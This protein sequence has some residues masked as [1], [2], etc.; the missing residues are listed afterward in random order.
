MLRVEKGAE[1]LYSIHMEHTH[2]NIWKHFDQNPLTHSA[3]HY[4]MTIKNLITENGYARLTDI[5]RSLNITPGSCSLSLKVLKKKGWI[6]EDT[7]KFLK[8][9]TTGEKL[10]NLVERNGE[11]LQQ[12]FQEVLGVSEWQSEI[13]SCKME[14]LLSIETSE[15]L[16]LF[17][18][19]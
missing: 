17:L 12:F 9:S 3:A 19:K 8:L 4:L 1:I 15:K 11:L 7:N 6:D 13:D 16:E 5:A 2:E 10:A 18:K 14:H